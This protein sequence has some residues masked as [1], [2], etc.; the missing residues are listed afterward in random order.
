MGLSLGGSMGGST[1]SSTGSSSTD[2]KNSADQQR[3]QSVL[4]STLQNNLAA[5]N[6]GVL[7]PGTQAM[8]TQASDQINKTSKA[9]LDQTDQKL[10]E[11][12]F[13]KS[14]QT[15]QAT[16][17]SELAREGAQG[18]NAAS[19]AG[20]QQQMNSQNLLAALNYAFTSLGSS[21]SGSS[22]GDSSSWGV[23]AGAAAKVPGFG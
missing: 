14:G 2:V 23:S 10:A 17:Q 13:G 15:G 11:R 12:G 19:F 21:S 9:G 22:T 6:G 1:S 18:N 7:S 3:L 4:G 8:E 20:Q 16:L 5:A